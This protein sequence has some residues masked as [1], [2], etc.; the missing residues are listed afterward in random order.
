MAT[1]PRLGNLTGEY[2][3]IWGG[4][5]HDSWSRLPSA[6]VSQKKNSCWEHCWCCRDSDDAANS[7]E[8]LAAAVLG[9]A[10]DLGSA[11]CRATDAGEAPEGWGAGARGSDPVL[12]TGL[13]L[14]GG[15]SQDDVVDVADDAVDGGPLQV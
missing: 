9:A 12:E 4:I 15:E 6:P 13:G 11:E 14:T 3:K 5:P 10:V 1:V 2:D 8:P 7:R